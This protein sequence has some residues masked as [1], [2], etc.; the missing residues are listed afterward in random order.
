[1][2]S[3][4]PNT[5]VEGSNEVIRKV[6]V[7]TGA[8]NRSN[9][10]DKNGDEI[11]TTSAIMRE[12][13]KYRDKN[14]MAASIKT[15]VN[16]TIRE[17]TDEDVK[18][19]KAFATKTGDISTLSANDIGCI[20]LTLRLQIETGDVT[21]LKSDLIPLDVQRI[22]KGSSNNS[23]F[24]N[25]WIGPDNLYSYYLK[26]KTT[27]KAAVACMTTDFAMQNVLIQMGLNTITLDGFEIKTIKT[28]GQI[29]RACSAVYSNTVRQ[30]CSKCG[31][32]T[33]DRA[34]VETDTD[35]NKV[36]VRDH[37]RWI[38]NRGTI[39]TQPKPTTNR[40]SQPFIV[41]EDQMLM[42]GY[43]DYIR[44][45]NRKNRMQKLL[46]EENDTD[47]RNNKGSIC[48]NNIPIGLGRG[49]P[50]SNRWMRMHR[51]MLNVSK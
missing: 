19:V 6:V 23:D 27:S 17:P 24:F 7:D 9:Y 36:I 35:T 2:E 34:S 42:P 38:N 47:V 26:A 11:Y 31:N 8:F 25:R 30:F 21:N 49:N 4:C 43:R 46:Y 20:A 18:F 50:N 16:A 39:Y 10:L 41:A 48:A 44:N 28:W 3:Q 51:G 14:P 40:N 29:C 13:Q 45:L 37:R 15:L 5:P 1:M 22:E 12:I 32:A 33:L